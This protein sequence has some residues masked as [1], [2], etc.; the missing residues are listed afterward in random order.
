M[1]DMNIYY[2][3]IGIPSIDID[4]YLYRFLVDDSNIIISELSV[5]PEAIEEISKI[6]IDNI[7]S[8]SES[9]ININYEYNY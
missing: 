1:V 2:N 6:I 4:G 5:N 9:F 8:L 3:S 7:N